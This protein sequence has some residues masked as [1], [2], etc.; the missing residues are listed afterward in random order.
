MTARRRGKAAHRIGA[1]P[2]AAAA[3]RAD[4][5]TEAAPHPLFADDAGMTRRSGVRLPGGGHHGTAAR[6]GM[7]SPPT[8]APA[9]LAVRVAWR[10]LSRPAAILVAALELLVALPAVPSGI[11]L[12]RDGMGMDRAWIDHT[13][14]PD[15]TIPG[16]LLLVVIGGGTAAAAAVTLARPRAGRPV[17]LAAGAVLLLWLTVETLMI[18]WH[19]GPQLAL[20]LA[21]GGLGGALA[22]VGLRGLEVRS[23]P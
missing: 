16:V 23:T 8:S 20:D 12:M 3:A 21:Y 2:D 15:Y 22:T 10:G 9:G 7:A 4:H 11:A 13:L 14:L 1:R 19:G 17:A 6:P 18:G 5:P